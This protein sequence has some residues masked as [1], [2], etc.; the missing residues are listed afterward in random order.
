MRFILVTIISLF[1]FNCVKKQSSDPLPVIEYKSFT[2]S[3]NGVKDT[4]L[5]VL[6]YADGDGDIFRDKTSDGPNIVSTIYIYNSSLHQFYPDT[7]LLTHD[8]TR[9][10][11]TITQPGD[12][13][14]GK[15][16]R[17]DVFWPMT[18]FRPYA[19]AKI[20]YYKVFMVDMKNH[21]SNVV[22]T[23]TFTVN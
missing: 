18:E 6:G 15:Q 16:V 23:P 2:A 20:F 13:Y 14:K 21:K 10:I 3:S 11:Q 5:L 8:T 1:A 17:G 12:G 19:S 7:N 4:A 9:Y 22:T